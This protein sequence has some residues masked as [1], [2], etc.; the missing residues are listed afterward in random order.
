MTATLAAVVSSRVTASSLESL[1]YDHAEVGIALLDAAGRVTHGNPYLW[2]LL[3]YQAAD[4]AEQCALNV[5][6]A[7]DWPICRE[8]FCDLR[9][10]NRRSAALEVEVIR[11]SA[12][13]CPCAVR[14]SLVPCEQ[15]ATLYVVAVLQDISQ[16]RQFETELRRLSHKDHLTGLA[17]RRG[18]FAQAEQ[19]LLV[20]ERR[21]SSAVLLYCDVDSL[22]AIDDTAGHQAGDETLRRVAEALTAT[23]RSNNIIARIGGDEFAALLVDT[24]PDHLAYLA[25]RLEDTLS[26]GETGADQPVS[27]SSGFAVFD[28]R[29]PR[30]LA[31]L[32]AEADRRMYEHKVNSSL[33]VR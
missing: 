14:L 27:L 17:N 15:S 18:F 21:G 7:R 2:R 5:V 13:T 30:S 6:S 1:A 12:E 4:L 26:G 29:Q 19:Q 31:N 23:L 20:A 3:G 24:P 16:E 8:V 25:A 28:G 11:S 32:I 9:G 22:K 10:G 33:A